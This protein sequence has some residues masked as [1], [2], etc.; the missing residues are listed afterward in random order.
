MADVWLWIWFS[1][2]PITVGGKNPPATKDHTGIS[3]Y[4]GLMVI[5]AAFNQIWA[6]STKFPPRE[7]LAGGPASM[8]PR[9]KWQNVASWFTTGWLAEHRTRWLFQAKEYTQNLCG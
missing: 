8:T 6:V 3:P 4:R 7:Q 2:C 1:L 5:G 9:G